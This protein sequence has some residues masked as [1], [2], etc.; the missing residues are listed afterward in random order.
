MAA[1]GREGLHVGCKAIVV[2]EHWNVVYTSGVKGYRLGAFDPVNIL[3]NAH[4]SI[5]LET[6]RACPSTNELGGVAAVNPAPAP[7]PTGGSPAAPPGG[8]RS[9]CDW[10]STVRS[11]EPVMAALALTAWATMA[12]Q[13]AVES[14]DSIG[15]SD[16]HSRPLTAPLCLPVLPCSS[17][18]SVLTCVT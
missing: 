10:M 11:S 6:I 17:F 3:L 9:V 14:K 13:A 18:S 12:R 2:A 4:L 7:P 5:D 1:V 16:K 15:Y 8:A